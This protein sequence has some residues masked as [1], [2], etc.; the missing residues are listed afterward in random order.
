MAVEKINVTFPAETIEKLHR[1]VPAG[2]RSHVIAE[3]TEHYLEQ[4]TQRAVLHDIAGLWKDRTTLRTQ[5]DVN[6]L[7]KQLRGSTRARLTRLAR[8]G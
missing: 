7:L 6:R 4:L 2:K 8:R 1:L 3:A 5:T